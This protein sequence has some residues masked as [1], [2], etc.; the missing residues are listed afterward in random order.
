MNTQRKE[1]LGIAHAYHSGQ[2]GGLNDF[3][4]PTSSIFHDFA[5]MQSA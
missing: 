3:T 5:V 1:L 2:G 4:H